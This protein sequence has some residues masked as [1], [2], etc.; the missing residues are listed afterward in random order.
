MVKCFLDNINLIKKINVTLR[1]STSFIFVKSRKIVYIMERRMDR[2]R[3]KRNCKTKDTKD[4]S[5]LPGS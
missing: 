4:I 5:S 1:V 2:R 3:K